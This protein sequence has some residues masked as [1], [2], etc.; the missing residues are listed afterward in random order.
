MPLAETHLF[1][2]HLIY[3]T[4]VTVKVYIRSQD[5]SNIYSPIF[6]YAKNT[7]VKPCFSLPFD[8]FILQQ[9]LLIRV[10]NVKFA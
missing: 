9:E 2:Y 10:L 1:I 8:D 6:R 4:S 5:I 7:K 3:S